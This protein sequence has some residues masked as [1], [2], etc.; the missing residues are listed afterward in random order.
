MWREASSDE[1]RASSV[2]GGVDFG[3]LI[4]TD[5]DGVTHYGVRPSLL[6]RPFRE[7][8]LATENG[9]IGCKWPGDLVP[10][11]LDAAVNVSLD[12]CNPADCAVRY[13]LVALMPDGRKWSNLFDRNGNL[14]SEGWM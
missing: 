3:P 11:G 10:A 13:R 4:I 6:K 7:V 2:A 9:S 5:A 14:I 12:P 1:R 8:G